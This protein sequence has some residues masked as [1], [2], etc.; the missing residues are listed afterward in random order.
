MFKAK[1]SDEITTVIKDGATI[2]AD[3]THFKGDIDSE[4]S[5]RIDGRVTGNIQCNNKLIIG[6]NG[7]IQGNIAG[8]QIV[9][10]GR[11][12]GEITAK[13]ALT[14]KGKARVEGN[15]FTSVLTIEPEVHFNGRCQMDSQVI[16]LDKSKQEIAEKPKK[17]AIN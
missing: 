14:I 9:I 13:E 17:I 15:L 8:T 1:V 6:A 2:I 5:L 4:A 7:F 12:E 10:L 11:V 16:D 3:G